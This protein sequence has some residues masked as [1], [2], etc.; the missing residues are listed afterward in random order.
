MKPTTPDVYAFGA[1]CWETIC[2][3]L[4]YR[5]LAHVQDIKTGAKAGDREDFELEDRPDCSPLLS[6]A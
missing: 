1:V 2:M 3:R 4:P 5:A 6:G